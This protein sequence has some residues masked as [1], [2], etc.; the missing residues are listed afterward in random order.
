MVTGNELDI[1]NAGQNALSVDGRNSRIGIGTTSP[2]TKL[3]VEGNVRAKTENMVQAVSGSS[4]TGYATHTIRNIAGNTIFKI[5]SEWGADDDKIFFVTDD[6]NSGATESIR[7]A[8]SRSN[9][10]LGIGITNPL[11]RLHVNGE[12]RSG[13]SGVGYVTLGTGNANNSGHINFFRPN[14][15][16]NGYIGWGATNIDYMAENGGRHYFGGGRVMVST[17]AGSGTAPVAATADGTLV[18]GYQSGQVVNVQIIDNVF[19][20]GIGLR[21]ANWHDLFATY[22]PKSPNSKII[23][24][25]YNNNY[26]VDGWFSGG[27]AA[28]VWESHLYINGSV[29]NIN[30]WRSHFWNWQTDSRIKGQGRSSDLF[31]LVGT[32]DVSGTSPVSIKIQLIK[33]EGDDTISLQ[34][35]SNVLKITEIAR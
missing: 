20:D 31:P 2:V 4:P 12:I 10:N 1:F 17:L 22:V 21:W 35:S 13:E 18:R 26:R 25:F 9:G 6:D 29:R 34:N 30:V 32:L 19:F 8:I 16:R 28:D 15:T 24:E 3:D 27:D 33:K 11:S 7:L 5:Q 14:G 23:V